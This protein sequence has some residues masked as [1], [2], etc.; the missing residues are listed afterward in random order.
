MT[1][2]LAELAAEELKHCQTFL[3]EFPAM[4]CP[5]RLS[6]EEFVDRSVKLHRNLIKRWNGF[7]FLGTPQ[8]A[9]DTSHAVEVCEKEYRRVLDDVR[10]L[11]DVTPRDGKG[12]RPLSYNFDLWLYDA[13]HGVNSG[14]RHGAICMTQR[15]IAPKYTPM[16]ADLAHGYTSEKE[17][18]LKLNLGSYSRMTRQGNFKT[19]RLETECRIG[20][21][22]SAVVMRALEEHKIVK[23][24]PML[25]KIFERWLQRLGET[26]WAPSDYYVAPIFTCRPSRFLQLGN[27][28]ERSCFQNGGE[29]DAN[30]LFFA[31]DVPDTFVLLGWR[32]RTLVAAQG[33]QRRNSDI[34]RPH[35]HFR[36]WGL[37]VPE[38][39]AFI[40]NFYLIDYASLAPVVQLALSEA[41]G[42]KGLKEIAISPRKSDYPFQVFHDHAKVYF[43]PDGHF[44]GGETAFRQRY[45]MHYFMQVAQ[46]AASFGVYTRLGS[47]PEF[48]LDPRLGTRALPQSPRLPKVW[49]YPDAALREMHRGGLNI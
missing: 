49:P 46:Y 14:N 42:V 43:N 12:Q 18:A 21:R 9:P 22:F 47:G 27:Y 5:P 40:S 35:P 34:P 3:N 16:S 38:K 1:L 37:A 44:F 10:T 31:C 25:V 29:R 24:Y 20:E 19:F 15:C 13:K 48:I 39:G 33:L 17:I 8:T 36:A 32:V 26:I 4:R 23:D 45:T 2:N 41:F 30:K 28:D 7:D 11:S 6:L